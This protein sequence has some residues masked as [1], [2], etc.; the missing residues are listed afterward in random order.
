MST[1][2]NRPESTRQE[3]YLTFT[4]RRAIASFDNLV[5]LANY[6][7]HLR[8]ARKIVW[9]DRGEPAVDIRDIREC[10]VHGARGGLRTSQV[11][12]HSSINFPLFGRHH[13]G[14]SAIAFA[15]RSGVNLVLL[16]ARIRHLPRSGH[17]PSLYS[18]RDLLTLVSHQAKAIRSHTPCSLRIRFIPCR[19]H[20]RWALSS[21]YV[22]PVT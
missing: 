9:R 15:I 1:P 17:T 11:L 12:H 13:A 19:S 4:P 10:L 2:Y 22:R 7:E 3:S 14:A 21:S 18:R 6:E 20:V 16:L 8:E 5:V